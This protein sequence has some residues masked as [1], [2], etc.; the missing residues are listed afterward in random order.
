MSQIL[1]IF[2]KD[3]RRFWP[4]IAASLAVAAAFV[5]IEPH[6]WQL[7]DDQYTRS[8]L[9][10]IAGFIPLLIAIGW[11]LLITRVAHAEGLVNENEFWI[12]RP[13]EWLKL[14]TAKLLFI[15][16]WICIPFFVAQ[17]LLLAEARFHS[18]SYIPALLVSVILACATFLLPLLSVAAVTSTFARMTLTV[19]GGL[20]LFMAFMF[21][22][23][24]HR[25]Y[26]P[27][28]PSPTLL[29]YALAFCG[30]AVA[31][32]IQ[33]ATR[34]VWIARAVLIALPILLFVSVYP[35]LRQSLI[36]RT[37]PQPSPA[38]IPPVAISF[39]PTPSHPAEAREFH[40]N[41]YLDLPILYSGVAKGSAVQLDNFRFSLTSG[42]G[43]QWTSPWQGLSG[44]YVIDDRSSELSAMLSPAIYDRFKSGPI[45]LQITFAVT[46]LQ[47]GLITQ[48]A[49]PASDFAVPGIGFCTPRANRASHSIQLMIFC[50][51]ALRE[52]QLT[53]AAS[54]ASKS[55]CSNSPQAPQAPA[56]ANG[57]I[58]DLDPHMNF[59]FTSVEIGYL[60]FS[61]PSG[62]Q[63]EEGSTG[64]HWHICPGTPLTLTQYHLLDRTQ[65]TLTIPNFQL[66]AT[67][68]PTDPR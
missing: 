2:R 17:Y 62:A 64:Q 5:L 45:T 52:P 25:S 7:N 61:Y 37:Y 19:L 23:S 39:T 50:R 47:P 68:T 13:Y 22:L 11:G 63:D 41:D 10:Q 12:T 67:P 14:L 31:T 28:A 20:F 16:A 38:S 27:N 18:S 42:D 26:I 46:R 29:P 53:Y 21:L 30:C 51:S 34:R 35:N 33:Y 58:G 56:R 60:P 6:R 1:H 59:N 36:D 32:V 9:I 55:I 57:W 48:M 24:L 44:N 4:E 66:P 49:F 54:Y 3:T 8:N 15:A 65:T 40:G 43:S